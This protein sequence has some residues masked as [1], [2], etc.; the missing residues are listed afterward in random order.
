MEKNRSDRWLPSLASNREAV[1]RIKA[2]WGWS[3]VVMLAPC[4][5]R[6]LF[7]TFLVPDTLLCLS[8]HSW[9]ARPLTP[10]SPKDMVESLRPK[11]AEWDKR[12]IKTRKST[13]Q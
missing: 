9:I 11:K 10:K 1:H 3:R 7:E 4:T 8:N 2:S 6:Q 13:A 12:N 5:T